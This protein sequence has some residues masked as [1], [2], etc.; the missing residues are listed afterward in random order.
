MNVTYTEIKQW[1]ENSTCEESSTMEQMAVSRIKRE[2]KEVV[3]SKE[4]SV[5]LICYCSTV[6]RYGNKLSHHSVRLIMCWWKS[7]FQNKM[8]STSHIDNCCNRSFKIVMPRIVAC[9][10]S[11]WMMCILL[12]NPDSKKNITDIIYSISYMRIMCDCELDY[13]ET[14][15]QGWVYK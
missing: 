2:F 4:V 6:L 12:W 1:S 10:T 14:V 15:T 3:N 9:S 7:C 11:T 8:C 13:L 5:Q